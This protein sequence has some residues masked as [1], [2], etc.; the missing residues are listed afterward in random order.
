[1]R[2]FYLV[3]TVTLIIF[4]FSLPAQIT[5]NSQWAWI[6]GDSTVNQFGIYGIKGISIPANKPGGRWSPTTWSGS[7]GIFWLFG[8][9]GYAASGVLGDLNDLWKYDSNL[10]QWTW[11]KGDSTINQNGSYGIQGTS[12][13]SNK[14]GGREGAFSW[15]DAT[16]NLWLLGG[17]SS[18]G[19][20]NDLWKYNT[21]SNQWTWIKGSNI[22]DTQGVYGIRGIAAQINTPGG[23]CFGSSWLDGNGKF[24][25]FG[26]LGYDAVRNQD[27]LNDL[28]KYD[29][30]SNQWTW[31]NGDSLINILGIYGSLGVPGMINMPGSRI[32]SGNWTDGS[33]LWLFG[34]LGYNASEGGILNDL[35]EFNIVQNQWTWIHGDSLVNQPATYGIQGISSPSNKPGAEIIGTSWID[36][37][38]N[39]WLFGGAGFG[40]DNNQGNLNTLWKYE[41]NTNQW[42]WVKG[43]TLLNQTGVYGQKGVANTLNKPGGRVG[44]GSWTDVTGNLWLLAGGGLGASSN[45]YLN[46]LWKLSPSACAGFT[47]IGVTNSDWTVGSNWCGGTVPGAS[48][49]AIIPG[50]TPFSATLPSGITTS[51]RTLTIT[52]NATVTI[53]TNAHLNVMH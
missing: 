12:N 5:P 22:A 29:P 17:Q 1:M 11:M 48:D 8:G 28:W 2:K 45:G 23:R 32:V 50:G 38:K 36:N 53:G 14:P 7:N 51:V 43:D 19:D 39:L 52:T 35:W 34:G 41:T 40:F 15:I 49:D 21:S 3:L 46:D 37:N 4:T 27:F 25:L 9:E 18:D 13:S 16:G 6:S 10:N 33:K 24:W 20:L 26:G 31:V 30:A 42:V 47:W 44:A